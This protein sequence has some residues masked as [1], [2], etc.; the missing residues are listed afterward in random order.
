M[1]EH[2]QFGVQSMNVKNSERFTSDVHGR[3]Y[4]LMHV[5]L[6]QKQPSA[7]LDSSQPVDDSECGWLAINLILCEEK[8]KVFLVQ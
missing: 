2:T 6:I 5:T 3:V 8:K 4:H 7:G 1:P